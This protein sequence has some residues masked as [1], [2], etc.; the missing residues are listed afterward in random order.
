M[1]NRINLDL[2]QGEKAAKV[3]RALSSPVRLQMI[4]AIVEK[5][6]MN[7]SELA[8]R[9]TLPVSSAALNVRVLEEAGLIL[10][11]EKPGLRGAQKTCAIL[12]EDIYIDIFHRKRVEKQAREIMYNMPLGYYFDCSITKPCGIA[13]KKSYI[14][15]EDSENAFYSPERIHAQLVWF[16]SGYLEYRFPNHSIKSEVIQSI[17]FSFEAC[18]ETAGY[19]NEWPS[20]ITIWIN[21]NE[22]FTFRS[23][24]DYGDKRGIYNP[25]WWPDEST[26]YGELHHLEI[27]PQ[28]CF[29]DGRKTSDL[30][31]E[32]LD[33]SK[34]EYISFKI[35]IKEDA[36]CRGGINIFGEHFGNYRQD[37]SMVA[38]LEH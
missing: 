3:F 28:G 9:F 6:G 38:R 17:I 26:Q 33:I 36:E 29:G 7:I 14:G 32:S 4:K 10:I 34:G 5:P 19:N 27:S 18:S 30:G 11:Q 12:V 35:G 15:I 31:L 23:A 21:H 16:S 22:V 2:D 24:G 37:I 20:D 8:E 25:G 13:G 1:K